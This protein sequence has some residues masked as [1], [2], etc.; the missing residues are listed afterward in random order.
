MV[1]ILFRKRIGTVVVFHDFSGDLQNK[2]KRKG[3][4]SSDPRFSRDFRGVL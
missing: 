2:K 4:H 1:T 3:L